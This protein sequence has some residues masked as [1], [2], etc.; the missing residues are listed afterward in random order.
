MSPVTHRFVPL[1]ILLVLLAGCA[2]SGGAAPR[3]ELVPTPAPS[4][5]PITTPEAAFARIVA[6]EPRLAGIRPLD[7]EMIG[8]SSWYEATRAE[9][10]YSVEVYVGWGDCMAGCIDHHTWTYLVAT[11]GR[12][13][14]VAEDGSAIPADEW[15]SPAGT[16]KTGIL[17]TAVAGP[18][19]PVERPGDVSCLPRP[20][21]GAEAIVTDEGGAEVAR[22]FTDGAGR[23][24][25]EL[26]A[27]SYRVVAQPVEGLMAYPDPIEVQVTEG[28][29]VVELPYDTGIR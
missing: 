12:V 1:A 29:A 4:I 19:C 17:G 3:P 6:I 14:L 7:P 23:F 24:F 27:G 9:G 15:P 25:V 8:Q 26:G 21:A 16:G 20:V 11:D 13:G 5:E 10:G 2:A 22:A 28:E 18:T